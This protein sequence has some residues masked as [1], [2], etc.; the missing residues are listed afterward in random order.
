MTIEEIKRVQRQWAEGAVRAQKAGFDAVEIIGCTGYLIPQFLS[1]LT[2]FRTDEYGGSWENR[3]RFAKEVVAQVRAAVGPDY[4][5]LMRI[6][7]N[8][9]ISTTL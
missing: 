8:D 3:V 7:G 9:F 5:I 1:Q 4:P 2:N 6:A